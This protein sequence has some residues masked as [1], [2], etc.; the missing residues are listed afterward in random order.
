MSAPAPVGAPVPAGPAVP[1]GRSA[2]PTRAFSPRVLGVCRA[3]ARPAI[4]HLLL[5]V[6]VHGLA[7]LPADGP[8]LLAGPHSGWLDGP[9]VVAETRRDVRCLTKSEMYVGRL[10]DALHVL[11]QIPVDRGHPD[12]SALLAALTALTV[13]G[14]V[15][16][17]PEGT[18]GMGE[19]TSVHDGLAWL[20]ARSGAPVVPVAC[21][22]TAAALPRGA[23]WPRHV[24][25]DVVYGEPFLPP[26]P[27]REHSRRALADV[28]EAIRLR[29]VAHAVAA[30]S[31]C[32]RSGS[33]SQ[34]TGRPTS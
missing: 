18:R 2:R 13:G 21:I 9:I 16:V 30:R 6:H 22:G 26:V 4:N 12:R 23:R 15:G 5:D 31:V 27:E 11:G 25:V 7:H 17:F 32:P 24:H 1:A 34:R 28:G 20:A 19:L 33:P 14:V 29:L 3:I 10:S 8:V